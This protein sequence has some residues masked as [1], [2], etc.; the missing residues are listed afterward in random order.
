MQVN[1]WIND[2]ESGPLQIRLHVGQSQTDSGTFTLVLM[3]EMMESGTVDVADVLDV[4]HQHGHE[5]VQPLSHWV[6]RPSRHGGL[7]C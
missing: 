1:F 7:I 3:V 2:C 6:R 4:R 5:R